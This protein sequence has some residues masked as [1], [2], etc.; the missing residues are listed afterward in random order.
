MA[1]KRWTVRVRLSPPAKTAFSGGFFAG[2][3]EARSQPGKAKVLAV[4]TREA[5]FAPCGGKALRA[6][7]ARTFGATYS[8]LL[9][10]HNKNSTDGRCAPLRSFAPC[11]GKARRA[12]IA[13]AFGTT[14]SSL[15]LTHYKSG[16][17]GRSAPL[18]SFAPCGGKA[19]RARIARAFGAPY[20]SLLLT[21]YKSGTDG[22][23]APLRSFAPAAQGT[24]CPNSLHL[25]CNQSEPASDTQQKQHRQK[26]VLFLWRR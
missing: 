16:T 23:C 9:L 26:S 17:D 13:R 24:V 2:G 11:G 1:F 19:R 14:Y 12:R 3:D 20:S 4:R 22:R 6:R 8:S 21:H 5:S 10:T 15:L 7:I 25:R 18:R